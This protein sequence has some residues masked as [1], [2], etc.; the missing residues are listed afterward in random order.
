MKSTIILIAFFSV[1]FASAQNNALI[2]NGGVIMNI[3]GGAVVSINQTN[4]AG[5]TTSGIGDMIQ[6]EGELNRVA[7]N[8]NN[9]TG[10]Y[11][12]PFGV[13]AT[14]NR[15]D[16]TYNVTAAGSNPG[17][18]IASTVP[19]ASN[20]LPWPTVAPAVTNTDACYPAGACQ[21][22]SL[23]TMDRYLILRK[24]NWITEPT[25]NITMSY[26]DVEHAAPNTITEANI[27]AQFWSTNQWLPGWFTGPAPI[28]AADALNNRVTGINAATVGGLAGNF[29]TWTLVDKSNPLPIELASMT[30]SC[31]ENQ[32]PTIDWITASE[33]N[34]AYFTLQRSVNGFDWID[35]IVI[36]GAGNSN[37]QLFYNYTDYTA[38]AGINYYRLL[39]T[40]FDG[41]VNEAGVV[42][43]NCS[44]QNIT[45]D[46]GMNV[47]SDNNHTIHITFTSEFPE[48]MVLQLFDM[49]GRLVYAEQITSSEGM[50]HIILDM[51]PLEDA[52][53][54][55]N[56]NGSSASESRRFFMQ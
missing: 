40:D 35:V 3:T 37:T 54:I 30:A 45:G 42:N 43:V 55:F 52:T 4:P 16:F 25:S 48:P 38:P 36:T 41:T 50:N 15:I 23:Y 26:R 5:I 28:G 1:I 8:I 29:Y 14:G 51:I 22:R 12:V 53:Y 49:R 24:A 6:S 33:S 13:A 7:W 31:S 19:S 18:L 17:T 2:L 11:V 32:K 9:A 39:Q 46:F 20:N 10:S 47:Y 56:L 44:S 21:N 34:N 27:G